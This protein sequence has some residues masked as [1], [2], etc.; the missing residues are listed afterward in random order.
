MHVAVAYLNLE[1]TQAS[2]CVEG[3]TFMSPCLGIH[4]TEIKSEE[5]ILGLEYLLH[6][7]LPI[8]EEAWSLLSPY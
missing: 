6:T 7:L 4:W 3:K 2:G 5:D 1:A 8:T